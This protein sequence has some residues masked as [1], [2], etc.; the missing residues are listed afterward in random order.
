MNDHGPL[1]VQSSCMYQM[2]CHLY[3][4]KSNVP[5]QPVDANH[6]FPDLFVVAPRF[7]QFE[8][9]RRVNA[10]PVP[11]AGKSVLRPPFT[12]VPLPLAERGV[13]SFHVNVVR[14][15]VENVGEFHVERIQ[16]VGDE[17]LVRASRR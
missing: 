12:L 11:S 16:R 6:D 8:Q 7:M 2:S 14:Y 5:P 9:S 15:T 10:S 3:E 1:S 17:R 13:E 4:Y